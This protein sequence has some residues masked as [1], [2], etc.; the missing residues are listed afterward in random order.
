MTIEK[1]N[2]FLKEHQKNREKM[3]KDIQKWIYKI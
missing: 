1:I 3:K 2:A